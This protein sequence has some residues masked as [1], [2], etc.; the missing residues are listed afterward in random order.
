M[1][2]AREPLQGGA[3]ERLGGQGERQ[4]HAGAFAA[5]QV[6][7]AEHVLGEGEFG[8]QGVQQVVGRAQLPDSRVDGEGVRRH[9][10]R[11]HTGLE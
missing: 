3:P 2:Q 5:H 9:E 10:G 6:G 7:A 4:D 11:T 8:R 1:A